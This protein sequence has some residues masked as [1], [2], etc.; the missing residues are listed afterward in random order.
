MEPQGSSGLYPFWYEYY[1]LANASVYEEV[2]TRF[3]LIGVPLAFAAAVLGARRTTPGRSPTPAWRHLLGGTLDRD[4]PPVLVGL[5]VGL[6][7]LSSVVFGLAHVPAWGWWKFPPTMVAGLGMGYLFVRRGLLAAILFHFATDYMAALLLLTA[8]PGDP[9]MGA[10]QIVLALFIFLL[11]GLGVFFFVWY[12]RYA[13]ELWRHLVVS[14]G[15]RT[16]ASAAGVGPPVAAW[17]APARPPA[18]PFAPPPMARHDVA[19]SP[20]PF[21]AAAGIP[22]FGPAWIRYACPR[23]GWQEARYDANV[24]TCL[25]CGH[26]SR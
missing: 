18:G 21:G 23:C 8:N 16:P 3:L 4:S 7:G 15:F 19:G 25:R 5:A 13:G 6:V 22:A 26:A 1:A 12:L 2:V 9:T 10:A 24:F 17:T 11:V 14:W 20:P